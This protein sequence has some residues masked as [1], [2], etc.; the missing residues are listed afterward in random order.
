MPIMNGLQA[1]QEIKKLKPEIPII[2]TDSL[3]G[4]IAEEAAQAGAIGCL[5]KPFDLNELKSMIG[6]VLKKDRVSS[7]K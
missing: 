5:A 2:M 3:P 1:V 4:E 6:S 7:L